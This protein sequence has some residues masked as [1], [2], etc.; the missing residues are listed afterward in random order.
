[1]GRPSLREERRRE[2][3][4]A[5]ERVLA[6]VGVADASIAAVADEA[7]V[8]PGLVHHHFK[9]RD[10]L[11]TTLVREL[12]RRFVAARAAPP[13]TPPH[14]VLHRTVDA[15]VAL[16]GDAGRRAARAWV[17]LY[18]EALGSP[19]VGGV[20]RALV[21]REWRTL[22]ATWERLGASRDDAQRRAAAVVAMILGSLVFGA[23]LPG[24]AVGFAAPSL[25]T[26]LRACGAADADDRV[27]DDPAGPT[28]HTTPRPPHLCAGPEASCRC[29]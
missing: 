24:T 2:L 4:L 23:L 26:L 17:A 14:V 28:A 22:T 12:D 27:A 15:A 19:H 16:R 7:G 13:G 29:C 11:L 25:H 18:A 10:D 3:A 20:V 8:A 5:L 1:M 6:R 9:N 21:L